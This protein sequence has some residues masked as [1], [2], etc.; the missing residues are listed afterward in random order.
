MM[1]LSTP[2]PLRALLSAAL[3]FTCAGSLQAN[4][5]ENWEALGF[6]DVRT[7]TVDLGGGVMATVDPTGVEDSTDALQAAID[8]AHDQA[9]A[10]YFPGGT[11]KVSRTLVAAVE[12]R[13]TTSSIPC[14]GH[15]PERI[16]NLV[17]STLPGER[18]KIV[19]A[20]NADGFDDPLDP[21]PVLRMLMPNPNH[22]SGEQQNCIFASGIR[23]IDF[24]LGSGNTGAIGIRFS[25]AQECY[26]EDLTIE[27]RDGF[28]GI[29][30]T[31]GRAM[32]TRNIEI[33]GGQ[34]GIHSW[35]FGSS[36]NSH[37]V[38][39][40]FRNQS[41]AAFL[42]EISR[43]SAIVGFHVIKDQGPAFIT[44]EEGPQNGAIAL[45]DG[46]VE[47]GEAGGAI[48]DN[49]DDTFIAMVNVYA[50]GATSVVSGGNATVDTTLN[51]TVWTH[52]EHLSDLSAQ[53]DAQANRRVTGN[54][55]LLNGVRSTD[56]L[57]EFTAEVP[58]PH[59][60]LQQHYWPGPP[61]FRDP[62]VVNVMDFGATPQTWQSAASG[63]SDDL[64]AFQAAIAAAD[65]IFVPKGTYHLSAPLVLG[66]RTV[67]FGVPVRFSNF[68]KVPGWTP[69]EQTWLI[70]TV[71]DANATTVLTDIAI[72]TPDGNGNYLN[73]LRWRVGRHSVKGHFRDILGVT[74]RRE[75]IARS[76]YRVE[77]NG[78][79]RWFSFQEPFNSSATGNANNPGFRK[80]L[81]QGTSEPFTIYGPNVEHGGNPENTTNSYFMEFVDA[82]NIR[83]LGMKNETNGPVLLLNNVDNFYLG[84]VVANP[85][86]RA[87]PWATV[88]TSTNVEFD[89]LLWPSGTGNLVEE[90]GYEGTPEVVAKTEYLGT[91]RRGMLDLTPWDFTPLTSAENHWAGFPSAGRGYNETD[92]FLGTIFTLHA[93]W[94]YVPFIEWIYLPEDNVGEDGAWI[95]V[96][97]PASVD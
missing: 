66:P 57:Y 61:D 92:D 75:D 9:L 76:V 35:N 77:G 22:S 85:F 8:Q 72:T 87:G 64:A 23:N 70:D 28:A 54:V 3:L 5:G 55:N 78:G 52:V 60:L 45:Y 50:K 59:D 81:V 95:F 12:P 89:G 27:V 69:T 42:G 63:A 67:L 79:G 91:Y 56:T 83:L 96:P 46:I 21:Q 74:N 24:D 7:V 90:I 30:G 39:I 62:T 19:L 37:F 1:N 58:P 17:G 82:S 33:I 26:I 36:L 25:S 18:A 47:F 32:L 6:L 14:N 4:G 73:A 16:I 49:T 86:N 71:D 53:T 48:V 13:S 2:N 44:E 80:L 84:M 34:Y 93:P 15:D 43:G 41:V 68:A 29:T 65:K 38:N 88:N 11:Y 51:P 10:L 20:D 97:R 94:V 31:P 40:T